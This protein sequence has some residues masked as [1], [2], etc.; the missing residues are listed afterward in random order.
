[1]TVSFCIIIIIII[2]MSFKIAVSF[3][4]S[5]LEKVS[6]TS[7]KDEW[8]FQS[9]YCPCPQSSS[10]ASVFSSRQWEVDS[11]AAECSQGSLSS[12]SQNIYFSLFCGCRAEHLFSEYFG[13]FS[14]FDLE[15]LEI[16][17]HLAC[18]YYKS[19]VVF[20]GLKLSSWITVMKQF[21]S[22]VSCHRVN[23]FMNR[24][25]CGRLVY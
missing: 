20:V 5:Q 22:W 12:C 23:C 8:C 16:R 6:Q 24:L 19:F 4:F 1:M 9:L 17:F 7:S 13:Y 21:S 2:Y 15:P 10:T 14:V 18:N 3:R 11:R 25:S